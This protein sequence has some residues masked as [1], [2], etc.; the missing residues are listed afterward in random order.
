MYY[1]STKPYPA[2]D[3]KHSHAIKLAFFLNHPVFETAC[4]KLF[5]ILQSFCFIPM[6]LCQM[7]AI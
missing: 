6:M 4:R 2:L 3:P 7:V 5:T 1:E